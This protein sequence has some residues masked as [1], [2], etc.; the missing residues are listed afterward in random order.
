[1]ALAQIQSTA[2]AKSP[3]LSDGKEQQNN[4]SV[5]V[6]SALKAKMELVLQQSYGME[7]KHNYFE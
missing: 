4:H 7:R 1:M 5:L 6:T 3:L 2:A